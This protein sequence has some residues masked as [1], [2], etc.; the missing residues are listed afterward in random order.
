[1][2]GA[3]GGR[4]F[5]HKYGMASSAGLTGMRELRACSSSH[6]EPRRT[7]TAMS[8]AYSSILVMFLNP[9]H[10]S[11]GKRPRHEDSAHEKNHR[12]Q[13]I[14]HVHLLLPT[15]IVISFK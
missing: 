1:M 2:V 4:C 12:N 15:S 7:A 5:R 10:G 11:L 9:R 8:L 14:A 13:H 3:I 6:K